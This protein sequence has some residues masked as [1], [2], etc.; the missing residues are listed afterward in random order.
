MSIA[1]SPGRI[2]SMDQFRG[3]TVA[4]MF[5]VNFL[6]HFKQVIHPVL[7]HNNTYFSY[8]DSIMPSFFFAA[9]FSYRLSFLKRRAHR[10]ALSTY[11][12]FFKRSLGLMLVSL[13]M[14]GFG[15]SYDDFSQVFGS[16]PETYWEPWKMFFIGLLKADLW[17]VLALIGATQIFLM[18]VI[19][20][21]V[22]VRTIALV[23]CALGHIFMSAWFNWEFVYGYPD[24]WMVQI[25]G[26]GTK[27]SWDGGPFGIMGWSVAMLS[28]SLCYDLMTSTLS[29]GAAARKLAIWG[30][31][32]M[33]IGYGASCMTRLYDVDKGAERSLEKP[34]QAASPVRPPFENAKNAESW[35]DLLAEPPFVRPSEER[36]WL[37]NY[38]MMGKRMVGFT[39]IVTATGFALLL[40]SL[41]VVVC[42]I[43]GWSIGVFRTFGTNPLAAYVIHRLVENP[44]ASIVPGNS[45]L[46]YVLVGFGVFFFITY[47]FVRHLEK[48]DIYIRL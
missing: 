42:D 28:G 33:A 12:S 16:S 15:Q 18:P 19:G 48:H 39:F 9:G 35:T 37:E 20:R 40:Y 6:E 46:W 5:V 7:R 44:I 30:A 45:P 4:G 14:Y 31:I 43:W 13:M 38:W 32:M 22:L 41:F 21:G 1:T 10:G 26:T 2:V 3:Y 11:W 8:A 27:T 17:E 47:L 34:R 25:W 29:R 24:N 23:V 36:E